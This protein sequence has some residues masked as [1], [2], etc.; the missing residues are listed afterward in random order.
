MPSNASSIL[1]R[2]APAHGPVRSDATIRRLKMY[3]TRPIR[4]S[5][6]TIIH[7][8]YRSKT[9]PLDGRIE[10]SRRW[11][12]GTRV[13]GQ[14]D[15]RRMREVIEKE[16]KDPNTYLVHDKRLPTALIHDVPE[17]RV[18]IQAVEPFP[19]TFG[20]KA[21]RIRS[22]LASFNPEDIIATASREIGQ[23]NEALDGSTAAQ[24]ELRKISFRAEADPRLIRGQTSRI[25]SEIYK[26]IDSSDVILYVL[27]ARDPEGTRSVFL[28]KYMCLPENE[29][30]HL[31]Y[32]LNKCDLVPTWVTAS[33]ITKLSKIHPTIA[34]HASLEH[35]YG[36]KDV[37]SILRQFAALHADKQQI[38]V[39]LCGYPN[40]GKSSII[41]A[42]LGKKS[43]KTA[44]I[45]G[46]TKVWQYVSLTKRIN[47]IDAPGVI[48]AGSQLELPTRL[49]SLV[50]KQ[51]VA[52][53]SAATTRTVIE[54]YNYTN[55]M[56]VHLVLSGVLR[57]EYVEFPEKF[58]PCVLDRV[59]P[60]YINRTY[61]LRPVLTPEENWAGDADR[62]LE[63]IALKQ[64]RLLKGGDPDCR[65]I[66]RKIL[67]DYVRGNLPHFVVPHTS[68]EVDAYNA[69]LSRERKTWGSKTDTEL[70]NYVNT[71]NLTEIRSALSLGL[72]DELCNTFV[73]HRYDPD[74]V[75]EDEGEGG[76]G[77][78]ANVSR[79]TEDEADPLDK[80][81]S[82]ISGIDEP[83]EQMEYNRSLEETRRRLHEQKPSVADRIAAIRSQEV[84]IIRKAHR[85]QVQA[86]GLKRAAKL[87]RTKD[88]ELTNAYLSS[89]VNEEDLIM[90]S[91]AYK[92]VKTPKRD[93]GGFDGRKTGKNFYQETKVRNARLKRFLK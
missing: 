30:R 66:A 28:E 82:D 76:D 59:Q 42:L 26:V 61:G 48:W 3:K 88:R 93:R 9:A 67:D 53:G 65:T 89:V 92:K 14:E 8:A 23:Y 78:D 22:K 5:K 35:P 71:Q 36:R 33:W 11:F 13:V 43:C 58:I 55:T 37:F 12:S 77:D 45:P 19:L 81:G 52:N 32:I 2:K 72:E 70:I 10:P 63:V 25:H 80:E 79:D 90:V 54:D 40:A 6:G 4:D 7:E 46:E 21:N 16:K 24:R 83:L 44:P 73:R 69:T 29:H 1:G 17:T 38:S 41:N 85:H 87:L 20:P 51:D 39:G 50:D 64:G 18:K 86:E 57:T 74:V 49:Q 47:L 75:S 68:D 56:D 31:V 84:P 91:K 62:L 15:L 27:D 60:G 34:F